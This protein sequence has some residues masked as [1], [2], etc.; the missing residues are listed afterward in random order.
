MDI[1]KSLLLM[2]LALFINVLFF[3]VG[4]TQTKRADETF[5]LSGAVKDV[6]WDHKAIVVNNKKFL[7]TDNTKVVDQKGNRI[8]I[9]DVKNNS[10]VAIDAIA[11]PNGYTIK[12]IVVIMDRGV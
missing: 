2:F 11:H 7:I 12:V 4:M 3:D 8:K 10:D 9:S 6:S 5:F 1:K